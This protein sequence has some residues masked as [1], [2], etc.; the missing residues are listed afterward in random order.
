MLP[1]PPRRIYKSATTSAM[2]ESDP[3]RK[4]KDLLKY[5][6]LRL[7]AEMKLKIAKAQGTLPCAPKVN[8]RKG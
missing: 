2:I 7:M 4:N 3:Y 1:Q 6:T 5:S 8:E